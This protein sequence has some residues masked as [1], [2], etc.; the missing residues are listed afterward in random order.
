MKNSNGLCI[1]GTGALV[2]NGARKIWGRGERW[3]L[4]LKLHTTSQKTERKEGLL[5]YRNIVDKHTI[6][7]QLLQKE[8]QKRRGKKKGGRMDAQEKSRILCRCWF[9]GK[10]SERGKRC[11]YRMNG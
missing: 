2:V 9:K 5:K 4:W 1:G 3:W 8:W 6:T 10:N 11:K 7:S